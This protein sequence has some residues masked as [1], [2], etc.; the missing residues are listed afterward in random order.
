MPRLRRPRRHA[1]ASRRTSTWPRPRKTTPRTEVLRKRRKSVG[2]LLTDW[3]EPR[4]W[5]KTLLTQ[6]RSNRGRH[7]LQLNS[8]Q[9]NFTPLNSIPFH[10]TPLNS[11]ITHSYIICTER[12]CLDDGCNACYEYILK[13]ALSTHTYIIRT[14]RTYLRTVV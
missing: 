10:F 12:R 2:R 11:L 14:V 3:K 7:S 8:T 9:P 5:L 4:V 13:I 6:W 1:S